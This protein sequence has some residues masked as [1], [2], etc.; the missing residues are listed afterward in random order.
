M[1]ISSRQES[2][3]LV[4]V[5]N[6][7]GFSGCKINETLLWIAYFLVILICCRR[8]T[9]V[10]TDCIESFRSCRKQLRRRKKHIA[11]KENASYSIVNYFRLY[12]NYEVCDSPPKPPFPDLRYYTSNTLPPPTPT[13]LLLENITRIV[14]HPPSERQEHMMRSHWSVPIFYFV[15]P[16]PS[17]DIKGYASD[18]ITP[19]NRTSSPCIGAMNERRI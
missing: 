14:K 7:S 6:S 9:G 13:G 3:G 16:P 17:H 12:S 5:I 8:H 2:S 4:V 11:E 19:P 10:I 15:L 18:Q 1:V